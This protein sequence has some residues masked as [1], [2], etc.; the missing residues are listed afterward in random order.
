MIYDTKSA[1]WGRFV[2]LMEK[3]T[4]TFTAFWGPDS[5]CGQMHQLG[6]L[7]DDEIRV[8]SPSWTGAIKRSKSLVENTVVGVTRRWEQHLYSARLPPLQRCLMKAVLR[9][10]WAK[11]RDCLSYDV[12]G[13][14]VV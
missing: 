1:A 14:F 10:R 12:A 6:M 11:Y 7:S 4:Q 5:A 8:L 2:G 13:L 3:R 9:I